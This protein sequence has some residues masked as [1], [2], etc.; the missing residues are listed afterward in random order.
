MISQHADLWIEP[1][2]RTTTKRFFCP[3]NELAAS[4]FICCLF[5]CC[6]TFSLIFSPQTRKEPPAPGRFG[7]AG[8]F[9]RS[10]ADPSWRRWDQHWSS[11]TKESKVFFVE[12]LNIGRRYCWYDCYMIWIWYDIQHNMMLYIR[13]FWGRPSWAVL[14]RDINGGWLWTI[15]GFLMKGKFWGSVCPTV[16]KNKEKSKPII[17]SLRCR[18]AFFCGGRLWFSWWYL[19]LS[20][21]FS[22]VWHTKTYHLCRHGQSERFEVDSDGSEAKRCLAQMSY[23]QPTIQKEHNWIPFIQISNSIPSLGFIYINGIQQFSWNP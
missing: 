2:Q 15:L 12:T 3:M 11:E 7:E 9:G 4:L 17:I 5:L 10:F 14:W 22:M 8:P 18:P 23:K 6:C 13:W 21:D 1:F 16:S 20:A 19:Q